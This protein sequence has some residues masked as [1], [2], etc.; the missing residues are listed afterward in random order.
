MFAILKKPFREIV[1]LS[2]ILFLA[3]L[4]G[5]VYVTKV[6][7]VGDPPWHLVDLWWNISGEVNNIEKI[8][9]DVFISDEIP[10]N[11]NLYIA[12]IGLGKLNGVSFYGGLQ[13]N[14]GGFISKTDQR[15]KNWGRGLLFSRWDERSLDAVSLADGGF[16]QSAGYEGDFVGVRN[17]YKWSKGLYNI[18]LRVLKPEQL[19]LPED[20]NNTWIGMFIYSYEHSDWKYVGALRFPGK[21]L[22]LDKSF[23]S[24][25][26]IYGKTIKE[27]DIPSFTVAFSNFK[28]NGKP[29]IS[30]G[31]ITAIYPNEVPDRAKTV[32][33][34]G[35]VQVIVGPKVERGKRTDSVYV[36][37]MK[38]SVDT[39]NKIF[40]YPGNSK[41][42]VNGIAKS[43]DNEGTTPLIME[44]SALIPIRALVEELGGIVEW[45]G[46]KRGINIALRDKKI[47]LWIDDN[48]ARV[49]DTEKELTVPPKIINSKTMVPLRFVAENLGYTI[50][51]N[52]SEKRIEITY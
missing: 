8:S 43:I 39:P 50:D 24:F 20:K 1:V 11:I 6:Y 38:Y 29:A 15:Y 12:P 46:E 30:S 28:V 32:F 2:M 5:V 9:M 51:W 10:Q 21:K 4:N 23:A 22:T 48:R 19:D 18:E 41:M 25:V 16:C 27:G 14:T 40:L 31:N 13:T 52:D 7:A 17:T 37:K 36:S 26:E 49:N 44:G 34:D 3:L 42:I 33:T 45:D 47:E 35:E